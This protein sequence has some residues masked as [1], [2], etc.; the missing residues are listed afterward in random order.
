MATMLVQEMKGKWQPARYHDDYRDDVLAMVEKKVR[1][2]KTHEIVTGKAAG[3]APEPRQVMDLMPLLKR[4][5]ER[6]LGRSAPPAAR[7][8][9]A[10]GAAKR[11]RHA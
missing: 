11:R 5:L 7:A 3:A 8:R 10:R 4:S 9:P 1:A 6:R 2:G